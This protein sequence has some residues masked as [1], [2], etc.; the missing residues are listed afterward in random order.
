MNDPKE[1]NPK[2]A[3]GARKVPFSTMSAPVVAE[4]GV[5]ML[6]GA[7]KYGRHN[8][9]VAG[10]RSS[11]YYDAAKRHLESWWEGE[12]IDEES[13]LPHLVKLL[14][15]M[16][17]LRDAQICGVD[18][19]DR[20]PRMPAG[21]MESL[22]LK[23]GEILD[24]YPEQVPAFTELGPSDPPVVAS[25]PAVITFRNL[26][27]DNTEARAINAHLYEWRSIWCGLWGSWD[28]SGISELSDTF[29][30][31]HEHADAIR[32]LCADWVAK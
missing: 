4:I 27:G 8:W 3:I 32:K 22:N 28:T 9:R 26:D 21:W 2:Q 19:D 15:C 11:T 12:D 6:E 14:S 29:D 20:P 13:G 25:E 17:V 23:T 24:K 7:C 31:H 18:N 5:A 16:M 30:P 10:A 1:T